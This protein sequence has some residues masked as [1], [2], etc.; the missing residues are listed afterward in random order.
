MASDSQLTD[1][2]TKASVPKFWRI[3]GWL[4]GAAGSYSEIVTLLAEMKRHKDLSPAG[5]LA[6]VDIKVKD[7]DALL[8]S[9]S[10]KLYISEN[11]Q[12]AMPITDGFAA[13]GTGAQGAL[14]A[15]HMGATPANAVRAVKKVDPSTGGRVIKR[16]L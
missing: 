10:G 14:V 12:D 4:V 3:R 5:V 7:V 2:A 1:A 15:M 8:L 11:G 13:I 16:T 6:E 9:P